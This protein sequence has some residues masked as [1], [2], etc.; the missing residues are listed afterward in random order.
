MFKE[1]DP[2]ILDDPILM[3]KW[4]ETHGNELAAPQGETPQVPKSEP[5]QRQS[6]KVTQTDSESDAQIFELD[7]LDDLQEI[8]IAS[9][10]TEGFIN[11]LS[12]KANEKSTQ[13]IVS[14]LNVVEE[15]AQKYKVIRTPILKVSDITIIRQIQSLLVQ[16]K[17]I[18]SLDLTLRYTCGLALRYYLQYLA[19]R[20]NFHSAE[21]KNQIQEKEKTVRLAVTI[22]PEDNLYAQ[23]AC[24]CDS[25]T[26][27]QTSSGSP[28]VSSGVAC[29]LSVEQISLKIK[30]VREVL[31]NYLADIDKQGAPT[32]AEA[33]YAY[34]TEKLK[35]PPEQ[36]INDSIKNLLFILNSA[37]T[38]ATL[39][40]YAEFIA[41]QKDDK[42]EDSP[43]NSEC[44]SEISDNL[45]QQGITPGWLYIHGLTTITED[46]PS[47]DL[48]DTSLFSYKKVKN[49]IRIDSVKTSGCIL[50]PDF[51]DGLPVIRIG[52]SAFKRRK[53]ITAVILPKHLLEIEESAFEKSGI[54]SIDI[55]DS[56]ELIER[57]AF[58]DCKKLC[59]VKLPQMLKSIKYGTFYGCSSLKEIKIPINVAVINDDAFAGCTRLKKVQISDAVARFGYRVFSSK[60]VIYCNNNSRAQRYA[61]EWYMP[62]VK[63]FELFDADK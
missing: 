1:M 53:D 28:I 13:E 45:S 59:R 61:E 56:V 57:Y 58:Y 41:G 40:S 38:Y 25:K 31:S 6:R 35:K 27:Q 14:A 9:D 30:E 11:W 24:Q 20:D 18:R 55:P 51:I 23:P 33:Y 52:A 19:E 2:A 12:K 60:P 42:A 46:V 21:G 36:I 39:L 44:M 62:A 8:Y 49:G 54:L 32:I 3:L 4:F 50:I 34:L 37:K 5:K 43:N 7:L 16:K 10:Q 26:R 22:G 47:A 17:E 29:P 15:Y 63:P 48:V